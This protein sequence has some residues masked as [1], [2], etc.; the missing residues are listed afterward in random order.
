[1]NAEVLPMSARIAQLWDDKVAWVTTN[2]AQILLGVVI[3][4]IIVAV[5]LGA[6]YIGERLCATDRSG[7]HWRTIVGRALAR[8][9]LWF[10]I[11][12]AAEVVARFSDAPDALAQTVHFLFVI[13]ATLQAAIFARELILGT[14]E[15]RAAGREALGSALGIIRL[16]VTI[17]LFAVAVVLILSNLGV[18]VT[19]LVAGLG[20]G[21]IAIGLA[22]QGIFRDLFA[23]LAILFDGPF[24]VGDLIRFGETTGRVEAIG[25]KT[26][27][28]RSLDGELVVMSNNRL[29]EM[30]LRNYTDA[31]ARRVTL[32]LPLNY[33]TTAAQLNRLPELLRAVVEA[34]PDARFDHAGLLD[35]TDTA[36]RCE[37]RFA[38]EGGAGPRDAARQ[39]VMTQAVAALTTAGITFHA[40]AALE[41]SEPDI[42]ET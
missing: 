20:I 34:V 16:L 36:I 28:L 8:T 3:G 38:V 10:M 30:E 42:V 9:R 14:V 41:P 37:L 40:Q 1:M 7:H 17:A 15:H 11:A 33:R 23:A 35:F 13:T 27:R 2:S 21:G 6:K 4:A 12:V 19:G 24:R 18:N 5:L 26:T 39:H 22:A 29:L 32:V 25:L 31:P